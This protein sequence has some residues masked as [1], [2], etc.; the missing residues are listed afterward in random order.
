MLTLQNLGNTCFMNSGL[1]CLSNTFL[2]SKYFY[3]DHYI[4]DLNTDNPLGMKGNFAKIYAKLVKLF[5][6]GSDSIISPSFFKRILGKRHVSF[7]GYSQQDSQELLTTILDTLHED[8]N[9]IKKKPY[10][11]SKSTDDPNDNSIVES[12]WYNYL[13]RNQSI[14]VDLMHGQ[15]TYIN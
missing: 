14:I 8:L 4:P 12:T 10:I 3:D 11:E 9:R 2:L 15:Y 7:S 5:W 13:A 6:Y 1:Q